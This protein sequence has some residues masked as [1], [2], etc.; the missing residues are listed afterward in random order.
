[1]RGPGSASLRTTRQMAYM[2]EPSRKATH[3]QPDRK[4]ER[5]QIGGV[6]Q[7]AGILMPVCGVYA[8]GVVEEATPDGKPARK[9]FVG[10]KA[11]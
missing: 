11:V 1:M 3:S 2:I 5:G 4:D 6:D 10:Q 8:L 9:S 7:F